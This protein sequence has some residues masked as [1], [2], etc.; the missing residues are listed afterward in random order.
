MRDLAGRVTGRII[1]DVCFGEGSPTPSRDLSPEQL[2]EALRGQRIERLTRRGKFLLAHLDSGF[3][4]VLHR[5]M[6]GNLVLRCPDDPPDPFTRA[7]IHL[8]GGHDLRWTDQR[9]FG[10]WL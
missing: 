4:L 6:T 8:E 3:A 9:R 7:V 5:R 1:T 2:A 10:T